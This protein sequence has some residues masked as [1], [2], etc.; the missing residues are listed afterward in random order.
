MKRVSTA[1]SKQSRNFSEQMTIGLDLG[2]RS[3]GVLPVATVSDSAGEKSCPA[4][5]TTKNP[6]R[7]SEHLG[8]VLC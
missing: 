5:R 1:R 3:T 2:N 8:G 4:K 6:L 7:F